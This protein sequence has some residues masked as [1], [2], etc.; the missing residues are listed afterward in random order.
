MAE[1]IFFSA[2]LASSLFLKIFIPA[3]AASLSALFLLFNGPSR[4][5]AKKILILT[6]VFALGVSAGNLRT[7]SIS[8]TPLYAKVATA[9]GELPCWIEGRVISSEPDP[10]GS[11]AVV[12]TDCFLNGNERVPDNSRVQLYLQ[13]EPPLPGSRFRASA[14][15]FLPGEATNPGQFDYRKNL[16]DKGILLSG[17]VKDRSLFEV[18]GRAGFTLPGRYRGMIRRQISDWGGEQSG[19][20]L[21]LLLGERGLISEDAGADMI[22][23]GLYHLVALSGFNIGMIMLLISFFFVLLRFSPASA[24]IFAMAFLPVYGMLVGQQPSVWRAILMGLIFLAGRLL[25]RPHAATRAL[26]ITF[27]ALLLADPMDIRDVGFQLTFSAALG[28][29]LMYKLCP[30]LFKE[31]S[32]ADYGLKLFWVGFS[33]QLFTLPVLAVYFQRVSPAGFIWTPF[34]SLPMFPLFAFGMVYLFGGCFV[35]GLNIFLVSLIRFFTELFLIVPKWASGVRLS[36]LFVPMPSVFYFLA[37]AAALAIIVFGGKRRLAGA[38]MIVPV[39]LAAY[40]FPH[41]FEK[42]PADS[43]IVLDVGQGSCQLLLCNG[44]N[45]MVDAPDTSYRSIS[46]ARSVIEPALSKLHAEE[47]DG[48]FITHWDRDHAGA[49]GELASDMRIGFVGYPAAAPPPEEI[50]AVLEKRKIRTI[51]LRAGDRLSLGKAE[52]SVLHPPEKSIC[53]SENDLSLV[54]SFQIGSKVMLFTGDV[55]N[56]GLDELLRDFA[57]VRTEILMAPHHGARKSLNPRF[58][59]AASPR[60]TVFSVGRNNRFNHP[61]APVVDTY[62]RLGSRTLRTDRDGALLFKLDTDRTGVFTFAS[63]DWTEELWR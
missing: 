52:L 9:R 31:G 12:R 28:I 21:A 18:T 56:E 1:L 58:S 50:A 8:K 7:P 46:T 15:L 59:F 33:A 17:K 54:M 13:F 47:I 24:D 20:I 41:P 43:L 4:S 14:I 51:A 63:D 22:R 35:P 49:I 3:L 60:F 19:V 11:K 32:F 37:F 10:G 29:I 44:R 6:I 53:I 25:A 30:P 39:M 23:S 62:R 27:A 36:T 16:R 55:E 61:H 57:P 2:G 45:Y 34:A 48:L 40:F 42:A 5:Q 38:F 26:V